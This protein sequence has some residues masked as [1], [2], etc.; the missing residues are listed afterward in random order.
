MEYTVIAS[1]TESW[2]YSQ[3]RAS[4]PPKMTIAVMANVP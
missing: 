3:W 2:W 4:T 1:M